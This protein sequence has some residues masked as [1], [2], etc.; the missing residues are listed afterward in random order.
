MNFTKSFSVIC[1]FASLLLACG[2][3]EDATIC[4][5]IPVKIMTALS[6][7]T[8]EYEYDGNNRLVR[9]KLGGDRNSLHISYNSAGDVEKIGKS[10]FPFPIKPLVGVS[11]VSDS[12]IFEFS[13]NNKIITYDVTEYRNEE[14]CDQYTET[15]ILNELNLPSKIEKKDGS[16][17]TYLYD[18]RGNL[19]SAKYTHDYLEFEYTYTYDNK[20]GIFSQIN[21]SKWC[22]IFMGY[23]DIYNNMVTE[24]R[25]NGQFSELTFIYDTCGYAKTIL[26]SFGTELTNIEYKYTD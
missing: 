23:T 15:I 4:K 6:P 20:N 26:N 3:K 19:I 24:Q 12:S 14:I 22:L 7:T 10:G 17:Y 18:T 13:R 2:K 5:Q 25:N 1:F 8:H 21:T 11:I 9:A 16:Y